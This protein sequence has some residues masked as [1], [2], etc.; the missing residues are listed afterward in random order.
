[1]KLTQNNFEYLQ[2]M[3]QQRKLTAA[4]AN[5]EKVK[6]MRVE[7]VIGKLPAQVR[8]ALNDA[9][10]EGKLGHLK[11]DRRKPEAYYHPAFEFLA[12]HERKKHEQLILKSLKEITC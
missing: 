7:L 5:V 6:M 11:K 2:D 3:M 1:M 12:K 10:K 9:V 8:K 4:Q